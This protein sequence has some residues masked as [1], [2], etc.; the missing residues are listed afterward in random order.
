MKLPAGTVLQK[1]DAR[2]D[3][4]IE[5]QE[6]LQRC[7]VGLRG[8]AD[9]GFGASSDIAVRHFQLTNLPLKVDGKV[10]EQTARKLN[11]YEIR[12]HAFQ[13]AEAEGIDRD[14]LVGRVDELWEHWGRIKKE[15]GSIVDQWAAT[16]EKEGLG[17]S[18]ERA[19]LIRSLQ[20]LNPPR[21]WEIV[22][23]MVASTLPLQFSFEVLFESM[24]F[25]VAVSS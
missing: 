13:K 6:Q 23:C 17:T 20:T 9:G 12:M 19:A 4:V 7:R 25:P 1:G 16:L 11:D 22:G 10:G 18:E 21:P 5:L 8:W 2:K 14:N 3:L 15:W 24:G